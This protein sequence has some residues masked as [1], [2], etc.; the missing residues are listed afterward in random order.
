MNRIILAGARDG[1]MLTFFVRG[2]RGPTLRNARPSAGGPPQACA[3]RLGAVVWIQ[4]LM[5]TLLEVEW[6]N[7]VRISD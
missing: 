2:R 7:I 5:E 6:R 4:S 3:I 1:L